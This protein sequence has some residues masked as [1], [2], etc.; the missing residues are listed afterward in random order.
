MKILNDFILQSPIL[1]DVEARLA[2]EISF[3]KTLEQKIVSQN[4]ELQDLIN[5][6]GEPKNLVKNQ[7]ELK[8]DS[9]FFVE[10][11]V[12]VSR[13]RRLSLMKNWCGL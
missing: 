7:K 10:F 12:L 3:I 2:Y 4:N 9:E 13:K 6:L 8:N 1:L 11:Q 5:S